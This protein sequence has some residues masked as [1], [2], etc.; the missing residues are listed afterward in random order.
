MSNQFIDEYAEEEIKI[1][2]KNMD[3]LKSHR[4]SVQKE[5]DSIC[6]IIDNSPGKEFFQFV[7]KPIFTS[8]DMY[9]KFITRYLNNHYSGKPAT[10]VAEWF[11]NNQILIS[12]NYFTVHSDV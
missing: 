9:H 6:A 10:F 2:Q 12:V 7:Y 4:E 11:E 8:S 1:V 3:L 5:M